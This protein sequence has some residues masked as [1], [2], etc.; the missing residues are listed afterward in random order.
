MDEYTFWDYVIMVTPYGVVDSLGESCVASATEACADADLDGTTEQSQLAC[1]SMA[2]CT[3]VVATATAPHDCVATHRVACANVPLGIDATAAN[4]AAAA[5]QSCTYT[6]VTP[7]ILALAIKPPPATHV[8][9][10]ASKWMVPT[11]NPAL[12]EDGIQAIE[13]DILSFTTD[14]VWSSTNGV[15]YMHTPSLP[16]FIHGHTPEGEFLCPAGSYYISL[17]I[18][19]TN[20]QTVAD[21]TLDAGTYYFSGMS[22]DQCQLGQKVKVVVAPSL[23][24]AP[25]EPAA[26]KPFTTPIV[27]G[28]HLAL[29]DQPIV[30]GSQWAYTNA[31]SLSGWDGFHEWFR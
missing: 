2:A 3:Y 5:G 9:G 15:R 19:T 29:W 31:N 13:G 6:P 28:S 16:A 1:V 4:C 23:G 26:A 25:N 11:S 14:G 12:Y 21:I 24:L 20:G 18:A 7:S 27:S 10:G 17:P 8:V 22:R 30:T